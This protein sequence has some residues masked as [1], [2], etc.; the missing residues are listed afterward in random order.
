[1]AVAVSTEWS[2]GGALGL[3]PGVPH[4]AHGLSSGIHTTAEA[5]CS[6]C[7]LLPPCFTYQTCVDLRRAW[8]WRRCWATTCGSSCT[9]R[10]WWSACPTAPATSLRSA[11][12]RWAVQAQCACCA[13]HAVLCICAACSV[14]SGREDSG[15]VPAR[16]PVRPPLL[17]LLLTC[18][19]ACHPICPVCQ[20]E[21]PEQLGLD[22]S[23]A[24]KVVTE[25]AKDKK[26]TTLVQVRL[27][28]PVPECLVAIRWHAMSWPGMGSTPR[29][30]RC[31][32]GP[33]Q[34]GLGWAGLTVLRGSGV[35]GGG[36]CG[37]PLPACSMRVRPLLP[38]H[39]HMV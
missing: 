8:M 12:C 19:R 22:A 29:W 30:C 33:C 7:P 20:Q 9:A 18:R 27:A 11:C 31:G 5:V 34:D 15:R 36:Y 24:Q 2:L 38:N 32:S 10:R 25:L 16:M 21:L 14:L 3:G 26:H 23:K 4:R 28:V 39:P 17:L 35:T 37:P 6:L 1:M 13:G